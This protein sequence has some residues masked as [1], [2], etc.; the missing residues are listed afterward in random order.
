MLGLTI[1][2][3]QAGNGRHFSVLSDEQKSGAILYTLAGFPP[4][5]FSFG[6][7]KLAVVALLTRI[8]NP[9]RKHRIFLWAMT[10]GCLLILFGCVIIIF[11]QCTPSRSQWDF[12]VQGTC[13][14]PWILI[15]YAI[16][17]GT[18]SAVVDLYLAIYP[19]V[20]LYG[21]QINLKKKIALSAAL[22]LGS[23]AAAVAV[24]KS[25]RLP[26]LASPDFSYD[27]ADI[28]IWT[29]IEGNSII[30]GACIPTLQPLFDRIFG[31]GIFGSSRGEQG[32][33]GYRSRS[34]SGVKLATIGSKTLR[35]AKQHGKSGVS[36]TTL[37]HDSQDSILSPVFRNG[38]E[39]SKVEPNSGITRTQH[40]T[41]E[42][43]D[44]TEQTR[45]SYSPCDTRR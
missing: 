38:S 16:V 23:I 36:E 7:P 31:R 19:A 29:S 6:I 5:I 27:T 33:S 35:S 11:A 4:G 25:T 43:E 17:A 32:P 39:E 28:T 3:V 22:G 18:I 40:L 45:P 37:G 26:A 15:Y 10:G 1:A 12:S 13:W 41:V 30:I 20:V 2:A 34:R 21:L 9:S 24:Y 44:V 42:Y 14:S 8:T